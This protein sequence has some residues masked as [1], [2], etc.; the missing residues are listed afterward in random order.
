M[1]ALLFV[2]AILLAANGALLALAGIV[3]SCT[4]SASARRF[5]IPLGWI[6]VLAGVP[7]LIS[8]GA[9]HLHDLFKGMV[10][11]EITWIH[12]VAFLPVVLGLLSVVLARRLPVR[13]MREQKPHQVRRQWRLT[14]RGIA[15][16]PILAAAALCGFGV[17]ALRAPVSLPAFPQRASA[18]AS[19]ERIYLS[20]SDAGLVSI[21]D[22]ASNAIVARIPVGYGAGHLVFGPSGN[23]IYVSTADAVAVVDTGRHAVVGKI[24]PGGYTALAIAPNGARLY[25]V[26]GLDEG[27]SVNGT[28]SVIDLGSGTTRATVRIIGGAP[29]A[30]ALTPDGLCLYVVHGYYGSHVTVV[31]TVTLSV[32][33]GATVEDTN[34]GSLAASN[35]ATRLF[36]PNGTSGQGR[37]SVIDT[38]TN[39]MIAD[40]P[41]RGNPH[42]VAVPPAG[43]VVYVDHSDFVSAGVSFLDTARNRVTDTLPVDEYP[44]GIAVS[45]DGSRTYALHNQSKT[46][47]IID[48]ASRI[49]S[50]LQ[51]DP[52]PTRIA[53][54]APAP[55]PASFAAR[56]RA[57]QSLAAAHRRL[58]WSLIL[59]FL[60]A[61]AAGVLVGVS[62]RRRARS[63]VWALPFAALT[64]L[65]WV[66]AMWML[67]SVPGEH[68]I[69]IYAPHRAAFSN[70]WLRVALLSGLLT[71]QFTAVVL[72]WRPRQ[73]STQPAESSP[74]TLK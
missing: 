30:A 61:L 51:I 16:A 44:T 41:M 38:A 72:G 4:R 53:A 57:Y 12:G 5:A 32:V 45:R 40:V 3:M 26:R 15:A 37:V 39:R 28:V 59:G 8:I 56:T 62:L 27:H 19:G 69:Y 13:P 11:T 35:D 48:T 20:H 64:A 10:R 54:P 43:N 21:L 73:R 22:V 49:V 6:A 46:V 24:E 36:V 55:D 71:V 33:Q 29:S 70:D 68:L 42:A 50:R 7:L 1:I 58:R 34:W 2:L 23:R 18:T 63:S 66:V 65:L 52:P 14:R 9:M 67:R 31:D 17:A 47:S 74:S 25:G 60:G